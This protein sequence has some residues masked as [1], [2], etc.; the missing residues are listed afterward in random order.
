[1]TSA[2]LS[3]WQ[4]VLRITLLSS[5]AG[6][7]GIA[8]NSENGGTRQIEPVAPYANLPDGCPANAKPST[9]TQLHACLQGLVFDATETVGDEQRLM[10]IGSGPGTGLP[11]AGNP[12]HNCRY[13]P[14]A[15][16][17][18]VMGSQT[19]TDSALGE[20]RIIARM[21]LRDG[22][23]ESYTK[24]G[25]APGDTTYWWV[26]TGKD[27]SYFVRDSSGN[28]AAVGRPLER[29]PHP[30]AF[31]QALARWI[32]DPNDERSNGTCGSSCCKP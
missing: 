14:L 30:E 21:F 2:L 29:T 15:K 19:Y 4:L 10:V 20:G 8:C 26:H 25:L 16:I 23:T 7:L 12:D 18:P 9:T 11:C 13:G 1:M 32:W 6:T 28:L 5:V 22:E 17:E 31:Q 27:S 24:F 3:P